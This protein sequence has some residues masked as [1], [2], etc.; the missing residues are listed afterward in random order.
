MPPVSTRPGIKQERD[1]V[2]AAAAEF[3]LELLGIF[4]AILRYQTPFFETNAMR[5]AGT[6]TP[7]HWRLGDLGVFRRTERVSG[8]RPTLDTEPPWAERSIGLTR[9]RLR[10]KQSIGFPSPELRSIVPGDILPSV[11][12]R[13]PRRANADVWTSGNRIFACGG[14]STLVTIIDALAARQ[15]PEVAVEVQEGR[16][17]AAGEAALVAT[18]AQQVQDVVKWESAEFRNSGT[19]DRISKLGPIRDQPTTLDR[20]G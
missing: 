19:L 1:R 10:P 12:R 6:A 3:G 2:K 5:A 13:D 14:T 11:S 18:A 16:T 7:N 4:E 17:L 20:T 15:M 8:L 9:F